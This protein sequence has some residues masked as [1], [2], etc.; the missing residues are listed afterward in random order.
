M[1]LNQEP[2]LIDFIEALSDRERLFFMAYYRLGNA[3]DARYS[4]SKAIRIC[5]YSGARA[6]QAAYKMMKRPRVKAVFAAYDKFMLDAYLRNF[7]AQSRK[8]RG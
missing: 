3:P 4:A 2:H 8:A 7:H 6:N 5:G 1:T